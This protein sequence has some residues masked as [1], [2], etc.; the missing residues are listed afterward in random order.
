[1]K[2]PKKGKGQE[3][4]PHSEQEGETPPTSSISSLGKKKK[5]RLAP[6]CILRMERRRQL[7]ISNDIFDGEIFYD[8]HYYNERYTTD[9]AA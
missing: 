3:K 2:K 6:S 7:K 4:K 8:F 9:I 5:K 1:M